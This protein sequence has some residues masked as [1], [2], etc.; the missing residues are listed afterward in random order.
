[1]PDRSLF[2]LPDPWTDSEGVARALADLR[3]RPSV[4][5]MMFTHCTYACPRLLADLQ[6][7]EQQLSPA[8]RSGMRFL[9]FSMDPARDTPVRLRD[10][11]GEREL[12]AAHWKLL[13]SNLD[14][15]R[16]LAAVLGVRYKQLPSGDFAHSNVYFVLDADGVVVH[17]QEGFGSDPAPA[18]TALRRHLP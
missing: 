17:R 9:L 6:R 18:I 8:E 5:A 12:A 14:A 16:E 4:V 11:R 10:Y 15:V 13:T 1:M 7:L 3:G 2:L